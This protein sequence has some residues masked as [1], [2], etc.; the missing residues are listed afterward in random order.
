MTYFQSLSAAGFIA[1][2]ISY[3]PARMGF[4][5]FVPE[6]RDSFSM[7]SSAVGV[8]SSL[9][10]L[11]MF[12]GLLLA[13]ALLTRRGPELP[14][15][16]GLFA[17]MFG[18]TLVAAAP[19]VPVLAIGVFIAASSA[20][21]AWTPFNDA[22]NRKVPDF[23]RPAALSEI[24]TGTSIGI[25]AAGI[26]A[27]ALMATDLSWR[28]TWTLF[29]AAAAVA[30]VV[31]W[32]ALRHVERGELGP[33]HDWRRLLQ[34]DALPLYV[35]AFVLGFVS[36]VYISFAGDHLRQTGGVPGL[37]ATAM[38]AVLFL[39]YGLFGLPAVMTSRVRQQVGLP[40]LLRGLLVAGGL[41]VA[42]LAIAPAHWGGLILSAGLQGLFVMML[43]ALLSFWSERLFPSL[44]SL[45]FTAA[46][47]AAAAGS[48]L[49]PALA[50]VLL[51]RFSATAM[52]LAA[53]MLPALTAV[54]L[55]RH[56]VQE[57][58]AGA[59]VMG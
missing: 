1:T 47:L 7:S 45:G 52:F 39:L 6:F 51:D 59:V 27:L 58:P 44:P 18:L 55:R 21:F 38:P 9:G 28:T 26:A 16:L 15:L 53:A 54:L 42:S 5:L 17:A 13:Q 3:G 40:W 33:D 43:S 11:G 41:S 48:V 34:S 46:L 10:F 22:V 2:A 57:R 12:F 56:H 36:S 19:S 14:V 31:N 37:P 8:V 4:G 35:I 50:G 23:D 24:S 49:G 20:G 30:L 25:V 32:A 29:A